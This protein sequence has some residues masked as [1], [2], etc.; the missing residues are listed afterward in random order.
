MPSDRAIPDN[1]DPLV[2]EEIDGRLAAVEREQNVR[3]PIAIES[4]SRAWGFPSP[5]SDYDC[6]FIYVRRAD[7]YLSLWPPRD[8]IETPL[9]A[10]FDVNGWD[11]GKL[12]ALIVKG[13][14]VA[15]E[16]LQSPIRYRFDQVM[17]D[18]LLDLARVV[19]DGSA[20]RHHYYSLARAQWTRLARYPDAVP[21]K[22]VFYVLRP[23]AAIRWLDRYPSY[24]VAPMALQPLL[25]DIQLSGECRAEIADLLEAKRQSH[26]LGTGRM[27]K[28]LRDFIAKALA[29]Y[30]KG[31]ANTMPD[32]DRRIAADLAFRDLLTEF[33]PE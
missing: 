20:I 27:P 30:R 16:W 22:K 11:I 24:N 6:R 10:V 29:D 3:I 23:I 5:D 25:D 26:E 13:N 21:L 17:A 4:G 8:V 2:V 32:S 19:A 18:R 14:A 12:I 1:F 7:D 15:I 9:D 28:A 31:D 33:A